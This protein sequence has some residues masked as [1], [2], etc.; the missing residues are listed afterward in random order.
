MLNL[1]IVRL[2]TNYLNMWTVLK[3]SNGK[4]T[5]APELGVPVLLIIEW[6]TDSKLV[7]PTVS[8]RK[9]VKGYPVWES[10]DGGQLSR[11]WVPIK[12]MPIPKY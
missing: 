6:N 4:Y 8:M 7:V 12:W 3:I 5:N 10:T 2:L 1:L 11:R 9:M